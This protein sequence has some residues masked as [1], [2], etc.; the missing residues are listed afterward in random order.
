[1]L[2]RDS[3]TAVAAKAKRITKESRLASARAL[4]DRQFV[5]VEFSAEDAA[6][7][8][9]ILGTAFDGFCKRDNPRSSKDTR[10]LY[11]CFAGLWKDVSWRKF[12]VRPSQVSLVKAALREA[13]YSDTRDAFYAL[14]PKECAVCKGLDDLTVD[15]VGV[16]FIS[17]ANDWIALRG[18][19]ALKDGPHGLGR[20][21]A[22]LDTEAD[23][24]AFHASRATYQI[25][26]RPC[27]SRKGAR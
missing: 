15:H 6:S 7:M 5:G 21:I 26:C 19:P 20:M 23:W 3:V 8:N 1:M 16:P 9:E 22:D 2:S 18:P 11:A 10:H 12:I 25:L 13:V 17:I 24:I 4:L 14:V 27:N